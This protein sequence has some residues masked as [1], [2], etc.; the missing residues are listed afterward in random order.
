M[1]NSE[2][3]N[4]QFYFQLYKIDLPPVF[5][6]D[7]EEEFDN[8]LRRLEVSLAASDDSDSV[9]NLVTTLVASLSREALNFWD[10]LPSS[11]NCDY[12]EVKQTNARRLWKTFIYDNISG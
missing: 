6:G 10:S 1:S 3:K 12:N 9:S 8:W 11:T 5:C 4:P 2:P 7:D